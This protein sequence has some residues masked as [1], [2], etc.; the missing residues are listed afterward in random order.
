MVRGEFPEFCSYHLD[1]NQVYNTAVQ[2]I[3]W[4]VLYRE[5]DTWLS[6][7]NG[8]PALERHLGQIWA[9]SRLR[10]RLTPKIWGGRQAGLQNASVET[11]SYRSDGGFPTHHFRGMPI[12]SLLCIVF[13]L[14]GTCNLDCQQVFLLGHG[15]CLNPELK[16]TFGGEN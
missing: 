8:I 3:H 14:M 1:I 16:D 10:P 9:S 15:L 7:R 11:D 4:V 2:N 6:I 5:H 12:T 13:R